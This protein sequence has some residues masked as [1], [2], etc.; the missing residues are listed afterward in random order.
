MTVVL[1][2]H[3]WG[4]DA[5]FWEPLRTALPEVET[6]AVDLGFRGAAHRPE[7]PSGRPV[8]AVG[9]SLGFGWLLRKS[10]PWTA[11]VS[12]NG[13]TRFTRADDFPHGTH[14]RVLERM[15][16]RLLEEPELVYSDFLRRCGVCSPDASNLNL[17][18]S[19]Q[20]LEWLAEWDERET[21]AR[22]QRPL[23]ALAGGI[24]AIVPEA[25]ARDSFP[26]ACLRF[27]A[28]GGHLLPISHADWCAGHLRTL[29]AAVS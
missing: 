1:L 16:A 8:V 26:H 20:G 4:F 14:R 12:I 2:V 15:R 25:M 29:I 23:L 22:Q 18:A 13:F 6:I 10:L 9:H 27:C 11:L 3:G 17:A 5:S 28:D 21:L 7:P 24:D 19:A